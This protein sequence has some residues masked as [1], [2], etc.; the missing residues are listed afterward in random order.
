MSRSA[1]TVVPSSAVAGH[2]LDLL[3]REGQ[4]AVGEGGVD[5]VHDARPDGQLG[6]AVAG[7]RVGRDDPA[8][9]GLHEPRLGVRGVR[10]RDHEEVG[11]HRPRGEDDVDVVG[12]RIDGRDEPARPFDPGRPQGRL[13]GR[14]AFDLEEAL[15]PGPGQGFGQDVDDHDLESGVDEFPRDGQADAAV[16]AQDVVARKLVDRLDHS[17]GL[18]PSAGRLDHK[19][20]GHDPDRAEDETRHPSATGPSSRRRPAS[21][22]TWTSRNPTV[23]RVMT[24]M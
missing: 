4:F 8:R 24:V 19:V 1:P 23:V 17:F 12:V 21:V 16:A 11:V 22:R 2:D 13:L 20:L 14:V 6:Q 10:P 3:H 5:E 7:H 18:P 9:A 15:A